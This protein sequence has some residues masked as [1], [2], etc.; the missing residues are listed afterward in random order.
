MIINIKD[1]FTISNLLSLLRVFLAIPFWYLFGNL[2]ENNFRYYAI[3]LCLFAAL[4]DILDGFLARKLNQVTE[5]GKIIDPLADKICVS[6]IIL[7]LYLQ[8]E[9][10]STFFYLVIGRDLLIFIAGYIISQKIKKVLPSNLLGKITVIVIC[11]FILSILFQVPY[12]SYFYKGLYFG[13]ILLIFSSLIGYSLR[14][15]EFIKRK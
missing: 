4:T 5:F 10:D 2:G 7:Q 9:I 8:K 11:L 13:S 14:A 1:I 6:V 12:Y 15:Y 3:A